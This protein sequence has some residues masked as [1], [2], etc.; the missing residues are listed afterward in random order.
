MM[1]F[2]NVDKVS[3]AWSRDAMVL[4]EVS[5][6]VDKTSTLALMGSNGSGKTTLGRLMMG[7][8]VATAGQV[9]LEGRPI[10]DY[11]LAKRG[12]R[13]GYVFQNPE[14]QLFASSVADE[15]GFA[16]QYR[17]LASEQVKERVAEMLDLFELTQYAQAFPFNLSHGEKQRLVLA[18][19]MALE[20]EFII[21]DEPSTGLDWLRKR[22]LVKI[23]EHV[24]SRGVGYMI[25]SHD[26]GFC[27]ELCGS[28]RTLEGGRLV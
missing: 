9:L 1:P 26:L 16:L 4:K 28:I 13:L 11:P 25:I 7:M 17:G 8:L 12:Q 10:A 22:R 14:K 21:L 19:V 18:A 27:G 3:F 23:L 6:K 2:I 24:R 15:V 5:L 20:P